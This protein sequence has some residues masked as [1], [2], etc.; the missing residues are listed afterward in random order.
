MAAP[1]G[2]AAAASG[3]RFQQLP[4]PGDAA[5]HF[6]AASIFFRRST[7]NGAALHDARLLRSPSAGATSR[8]TSSSPG[9][10]C[11]AARHF[12]RWSRLS[13]AHRWTMRVQAA[14]LGEVVAHHVRQVLQLHLH[15]EFFV[16]LAVLGD[17]ADFQAI[18]A[19]FD[20]HRGLLGGSFDYSIRDHGR[21]QHAAPHPAR[22]PR[23]R[24][25]G[26][27]GRLVPAELF[28]RQ[29]HAGARLPR[30]PGQSEVPESIL[31][32]KCYTSLRDIPEQVDMVDVFRKTAG[33]DADRRGRD[34]HRRQG[35]LAAARA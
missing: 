14:D 30:D 22:E 10:A 28:R 35:A 25:G 7:K 18:N 32:E 5:C 19:L 29:V 4:R 23:D 26:P 6:T 16:V 12:S 1:C 11:I 20:V 2:T 15:A 21:H 27:V 3:R 34:R 9:S 13:Y 33:R 8:G 17:G 31:G 24:G